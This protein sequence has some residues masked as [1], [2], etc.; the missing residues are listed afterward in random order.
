MARERYVVFLDTEEITNL[1][2]VA[3]SSGLDAKE[4]ARMGLAILSQVRPEFALDALASLKR[5]AKR[6]PG[7]PA[8][9][10]PTVGAA[11]GDSPSE[12]AEHAA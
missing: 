4:F 2:H 8:N 12:S 3:A 9:P 6:G 1:Q 10:P 5:F 11:G 7:R